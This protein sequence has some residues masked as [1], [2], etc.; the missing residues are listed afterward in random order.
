MNSTTR[1]ERRSQRR[2]LRYERERRKTEKRQIDK[3]VQRT[4]DAMRRFMVRNIFADNLFLD[5]PHKTVEDLYGKVH[6]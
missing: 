6:E 2:S 5:Y 3:L 1:T 4:L